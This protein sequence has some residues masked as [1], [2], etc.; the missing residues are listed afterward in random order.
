MRKAQQAPSES[1]AEPPTA[2]LDPAVITGS[3]GS[4]FLSGFTCLD[5][6][7]REA[8]TVIYAFCRV[9]DDAVDDAPDRATATAWLGFWR[10]ELDAVENGEPRTPVGR[11]LQ[12]AMRTFGIPALRLQELIDGCAM[13]LEPA[14]FVD[15]AQLVLYCHR[16][17]AAVGLACLPVL[18]A[19]GPAAEQYAEAL[20]HA[21][22]LTNV[23]RDL[24]GDA[25]IGRCYVPRTWL[26]EFGI[27]DADLG[28]RGTP[29]LY[30]PAGGVARL[31]SRLAGKA[32]TRFGEART[33]L[34]SLPRRQRRALVAARVM[35]AVYA[36]LLR[37]LERRGGDL[38]QPR[39]RVPKWRKLWL[40]GLV[41]AGARA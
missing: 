21:L 14:V 39:P 5:T 32:R 7:R 36:D 40:A 37:R 16:V 29:G 12:R 23:L 38:L 17:A 20:G 33:L 8:M 34:R 26:D 13:D 25:E 30:L 31:C 41:W 22:Q 28:G 10:C 18:G 2:A 15:E 1:P 35:G 11:A 4:T 9:V 24:R 27:A 19:T 3:S 6:A